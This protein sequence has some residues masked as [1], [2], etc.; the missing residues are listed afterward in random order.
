MEL[1]VLK[2]DLAGGAGSVSVSDDVFGVAFNEGLV[3][4]IVTAH[5]AA[6]RAGTKAQKTR[7]QVRGGGIKPWRQKGS[8]RARAGSSRSPLWRTGGV[9]FAAVPRDY[10]QKVN[11]KMYRGA[12]RSIWSELIRQDRLRVVESLSLDE[13]KT[14][15]LAKR[16]GDKGLNDVL[17]VLDEVDQNIYLAARNIPWVDVTDAIGVDPVSLVR[18]DSVVIT[19]AAL[20]QIQERLT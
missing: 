18:Y 1:Q 9:T 20:N 12:M 14:R 16:L 2:S 17:L 13:P 4:Q 11:R 19:K 15:V 6:G 7:S 10:S 8:G 5:M 3:H